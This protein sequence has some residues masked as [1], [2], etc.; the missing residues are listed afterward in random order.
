MADDVEESEIT[1]YIDADGSST[2]YSGL[3]VCGLASRAFR[4]ACG[5][6]AI[7]P[8]HW[9]MVKRPLRTKQGRSLIWAAPASGYQTATDTFLFNQAGKIT[10]Q[11]VVVHYLLVQAFWNNHCV[12]FGGQDVQRLLRDYREDSV[13]AVY[14]TTVDLLR[15]HRRT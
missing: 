11:H 9:S 10:R 5:T 8:P 12:A 15:E 7:C 6:A 1:V 4:P 3:E 2:T 14:N 13:I